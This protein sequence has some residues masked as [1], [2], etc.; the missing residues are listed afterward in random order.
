MNDTSNNNVSNHN[1]TIEMAPAD[2]DWTAFQYLAGELPEQAVIRFETCLQ[3]DQHAREALARAVEVTQAVALIGSETSELSAVG[4]TAEVTR[5]HDAIW[6][7]PVTWLSV[8][9]LACVMFVLYWN[10]GASFPQRGLTLRGLPTLGSSPGGLPVA[11]NGAPLVDSGE[12]ASFWVSAA[13]LL[14][15]AELVD[16]SLLDAFPDDE[17]PDMGGL[18]AADSD[19]DDDRLQAPS[20]MM[21]ALARSS[22]VQE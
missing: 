1:A 2:A 21:A 11:A 14:A 3:D 17:S 4:A 12:L 8:A 20:W 16:R 19:V 6:A 13:E 9:A 22:D 18:P 5:R 10:P 7:A 15:N